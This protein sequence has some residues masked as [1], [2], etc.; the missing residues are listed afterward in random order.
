MVLI[1]QQ[2]GAPPRPVARALRALKPVLKVGLRRRSPHRREAK[3]MDGVRTSALT[4]KGAPSER[5][6][7]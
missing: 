5:R 4:P 7:P 2:I 6:T 1:L 3:P